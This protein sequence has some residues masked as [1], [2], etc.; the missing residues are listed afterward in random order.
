MCQEEISRLLKKYGDSFDKAFFNIVSSLLGKNQRDCDI[1]RK[2]GAPSTD[3]K[4]TQI[5]KHGH[6]IH[7]STLDRWLDR[8]GASH[9]EI[10]EFKSLAEYF[11]EE[12]KAKSLSFVEIKET[13][14]HKTPVSKRGEKDEESPTR[15]VVDSQAQT[16]VRV[17]SYEEIKNHANMVT[18]VGR[19]LSF[20][21]VVSNSNLEAFAVSAGLSEEWLSG[22]IFDQKPDYQWIDSMLSELEDRMQ[23][24]DA[25]RVWILTGKC[26]TRFELLVSEYRGNIE[27]FPLE[28]NASKVNGN[29]GY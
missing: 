21:C 18:P 13:E 26:K 12:K 7:D 22:L 19:L 24:S 9:N 10:Q 6:I 3:K 27:E 8:L 1:L 14:K 29:S 17:L 28:K 2:I 25:L 11:R 20:G 15:L 5:R 4:L 16:Q 23:M